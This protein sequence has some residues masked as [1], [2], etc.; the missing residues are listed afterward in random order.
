[1]RPP[2]PD[3]PDSTLKTLKLAIALRI[4]VSAIGVGAS[5]LI[6]G[7]LSL[8]WVRDEIALLNH[9]FTWVGLRYAIVHNR[10]A[11][12][13]LAFCIGLTLAELIW[14][15][16]YLVWGLTPRQG[17]QLQ[18]WFNNIRGA[19]DRHILSFLLKRLS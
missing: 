14:L 10:P 18:A 17:Q 3:R 2:S 7:G 11:A 5:W 16:R 13:A 15:C 12:I 8:W 6:L 1:M 9:Y 4:W 19:G